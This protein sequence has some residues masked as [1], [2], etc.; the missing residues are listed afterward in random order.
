MNS[1]RITKCK[2]S[3]LWNRCILKRN[4]LFHI[5]QI[6][7]WFISVGSL[8]RLLCSSR[9][10]PGPM[11]YI[12]LPNSQTHLIQEFPSIMIANNRNPKL[13]QLLYCCM[14]LMA[15]R[16]WVVLNLIWAYIWIICKIRLLMLSVRCMRLMGR[17]VA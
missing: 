10:R 4:L 14:K 5:I 7:C 1:R 8:G 12:V 9:R 17:N 3:S 11:Q 15:N 2:S 13:S 6:Q 16:F